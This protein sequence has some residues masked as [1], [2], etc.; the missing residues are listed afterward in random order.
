MAF[1][2]FTSAVSKEATATTTHDWT[3]PSGN[4]SGKLLLLFIAF[5]AQ[6]AVI[7]PPAGFT[8]F[9][10]FDVGSTGGA[11]GRAYYKITDGTEASGTWSTD[12]AEESVTISVLVSGWHGTTPPESDHSAGSSAAPDPPSFNP[13]GWDAEDT[14]WLASACTSAGEDTGT[15]TLPSGYTLVE[16]DHSTTTTSGVQL[17]VA[18]KNS[19]AAS[20]NPGTFGIAASNNWHCLTV[21]IRP[22]ASA[23]V[24]DLTPEGIVPTVQFDNQMR[25]HRVGKGG[26]HHDL[27]EPF[28]TDAETV[29]VD[30]FAPVYETV[31]RKKQRRPEGI[32][33]YTE[34]PVPADVV[35]HGWEFGLPELQ[36]RWRHKSRSL[37]GTFLIPQ[38]QDPVALS[39]LA[40]LGTMTIRPTY[41]GTTEIVPSYEGEGQLNDEGD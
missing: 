1:P 39:Y 38:S 7:T 3:L 30:R 37:Y 2:T 18:Y 33:A 31:L 11:T 19:N 17:A 10:T 28:Y 32:L 36:R 16:K 24:P 5:D 35:V 29:T 8:E 21:A 14:L 6:L 25:R 12:S 13:A 22:G 41:Y 34:V 20:E 26:T 23:T 9:G 4:A 15:W 27:F 40:I